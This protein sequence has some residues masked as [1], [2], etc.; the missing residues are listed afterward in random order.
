MMI[1]FWLMLLAAVGLTIVV[2][3]GKIAAPLRRIYPPLLT[4]PMCS[5]VWIGGAAG[6]V[7]VAQPYLPGWACTAA[8]VV[9]VAFA[10]SLAA[11]VVGLGI[12]KLAED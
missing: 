4:C 9:C 7:Y 1:P 2:T 6:V 8:F 11:T 5:G 3:L 12:E 10:C